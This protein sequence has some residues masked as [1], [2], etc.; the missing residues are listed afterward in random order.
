MRFLGF[1]A[2]FGVCCLGAFRGNIAHESSSV[3]GS[4]R[5]PEQ[6][7]ASERR[8]ASNIVEPGARG[9]INHPKP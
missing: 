9:N 6:G 8:A 2:G 5:G 1:S 7:Y 3:G 4:K